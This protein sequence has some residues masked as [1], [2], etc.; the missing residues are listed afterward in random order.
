MPTLTSPALYKVS[1]PPACPTQDFP[2]P[3]AAPG[4]GF[5]AEGTRQELLHPV[6]ACVS[7]QWLFTGGSDY[8]N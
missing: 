5:Q 3:A 8:L 2:D 1:L 4:A 7:Q 6:K